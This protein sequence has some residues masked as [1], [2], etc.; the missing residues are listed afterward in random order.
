MTTYIILSSLL[1]ILLLIICGYLLYR[2]KE[3]E[4]SINTSV[5]TR[6]T[7]NLHTNPINWKVRL[8]II[9]AIILVIGSF[10]API[11]FTRSAASTDLIFLQTGQIGD[12]IGGL[13]NPF[14]TIAGVIVT[15]LAFYIQYKANL[16]QRELFMLEL[17]E[18]KDQLQKQIEN[19]NNQNKIQQFESQFYEMLKLH[20]ENVT[21]M[22]IEGR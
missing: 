8:L 2:Q 1:T 7:S 22:K 10:F 19:Q 14:I 18:N 15:G 11:I 17:A 3:V 4:S 13:M 5:T 9:I 16:Q 20:R 6:N 21:E 12:T